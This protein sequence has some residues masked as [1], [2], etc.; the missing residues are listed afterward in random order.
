MVLAQERPIALEPYT[1][2]RRRAR[3][4]PAVRRGQVWLLCLLVFTFVCGLTLVFAHG[5]VAVIGYRLTNLQR[6]VAAL[7]AE[8]GTLEAALSELESL[9]RVE[10]VATSR[11]GMVKP[12]EADVL[13]V[14]LDTAGQEGGQSPERQPQS[15]KE[16]TPFGEA[17]VIQALVELVFRP[18]EGIS[19]G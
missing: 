18:G 11:L 19:S 3:P 15:E 9:D 1:S 6:E 4:R 2:A 5:Q 16:S 10:R 17:G 8:N 13:Y 7:A 14:A 12:G